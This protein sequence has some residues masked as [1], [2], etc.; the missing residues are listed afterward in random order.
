[1]NMK[2]T[3]G[4][5]LTTL[6]F[7]ISPFCLKSQSTNPQFWFEY[8]LNHQFAKSFN[9][10]NAFTYSTLLNKSRWRSF[11]Y[12]PTITHSFIKN[13]DFTLGVTLSYTAQADD[14]NTFEIR[15]VVG[16]RIHFT[17]N[18]RTLIR[19][20]LRLEQRNFLNL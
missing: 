14:Y 15:P 8:M 17:P 10:E 11:D 16:S 5:I 9:I 12:S 18:R 4:S 7:L 13:V 1:M 19:A 2:A 20:Y 6:L 3:F